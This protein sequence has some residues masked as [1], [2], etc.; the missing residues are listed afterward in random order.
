MNIQSAHSDAKESKKESLPTDL[1]PTAM[2]TI[3]TWFTQVMEVDISQPDPIK[4]SET[5]KGIGDIQHMEEERKII[6]IRDLDILGLEQ[7]CKTKKYDKI[8]ER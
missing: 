6:D 7:A 5:T 8:R 4:A 2:H 3:P 1:S